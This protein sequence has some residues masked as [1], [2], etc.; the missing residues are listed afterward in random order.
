MS[1]C[2][3]KCYIWVNYSCKVKSGVTHHQQSK[4]NDPTA[5]NVCFPSVILLS[6]TETRQ[7]QNAILLIPDQVTHSE[8]SCLLP[9]SRKSDT[10]PDDFRTRI[11]RR[12]VKTQHQLELPTVITAIHLSICLSYFNYFIFVI[13]PPFLSFIKQP[14]LPNTL[15]CLKQD[16]L[17]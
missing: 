5:P 8:F 11:M 3:Q 16:I 12:S 13:P 10:H 6:L 15:K 7:S 14:L 1:N 17:Q 4:Q 9:Q 2:W